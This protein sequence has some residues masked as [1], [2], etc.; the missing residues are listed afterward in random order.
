MDGRRASHAPGG[1]GGVVCPGMIR[2]TGSVK[3][4]PEKISGVYLRCPCP[5]CSGCPAAGDPVPVPCLISVDLLV[6]RVVA[7][8]ACRISLYIMH[9]LFNYPNMTGSL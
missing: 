2:R 1:G 6:F 7:P 9:N 8:L 5:V 3:K 4:I